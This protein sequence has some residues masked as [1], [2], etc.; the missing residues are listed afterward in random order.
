MGLLPRQPESTLQYVHP[1]FA[2]GWCRG[3]LSFSV[4]GRTL[5]KACLDAL[6]AEISGDKSGMVRDPL[7]RWIEDVYVALIAGQAFAIDVRIRRTSSRS[8]A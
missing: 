8:A 7:D 1:K 4:P 2:L 3:D 5:M 6:L